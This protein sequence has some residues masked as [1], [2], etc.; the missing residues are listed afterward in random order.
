MSS[1]LEKL[2][3]SG[4]KGAYKDVLEDSTFFTDREVIQTE[5]PILNIA[6][7]GSLNGGIQSGLTV[8]AGESGSYKSMLGL[9]CVKAYL[10]HYTDAVAIFYDSEGGINPEYIKAL[11]LDASRILYTPIENV[12][13]LKIDLIKTLEDIDRKDKLIIMID[14]I[15][16]LASNKE[17]EDALNDKVTAEMQRAKIIKGL[18]RAVCPYLISRDVP[19]IAIAHTYKTMEMY[20]KDIISGGSGN[21]YS[22]NQAFV[23]SKRKE[24][25]GTELKGF[26]FTINIHK[27]R[28]VIQDSKL[29]FEVYFKTGIDRYSSLFDLAIES[30]H[31]QAPS[32]GWYSLVDLST[33]E[34]YNQKIRRSD[35]MSNTEF[36]EQLIK[37]PSFQEFVES[38]YKL[39]GSL[40]R[41]KNIEDRRTYSEESDTE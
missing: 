21:M 29:P 30:G 4:M 12:E 20:S 32:K 15:G 28:S 9:F 19:C 31:I 18:W 24:K 39:N 3:K 17:I 23:I 14:S 27:S 11:G 38:K 13:K 26:K 2:M 6:F 8:F 5:L 41:E 25:D 1:L 16:N 37:T 22:A 10:D 33:G 36:F 35:I 40:N 7:S 34:V